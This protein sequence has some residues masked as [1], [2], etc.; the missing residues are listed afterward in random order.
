M[1]LYLLI[2][3]V[4][5]I[6]IIYELKQKHH[7]SCTVSETRIITNPTNAKCYYFFLFFLSLSPPNWFVLIKIQ[8]A[9]KWPGDLKMKVNVK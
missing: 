8:T 5:L 9:V 4:E 3:F 7:P 6:S 2:L 1:I